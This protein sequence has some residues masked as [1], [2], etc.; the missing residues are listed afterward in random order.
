MYEV[1]EDTFRLI[2]PITLAKGGVGKAREGHK[3]DPETGEEGE[4]EFVPGEEHQPHRII[5]GPASVPVRDMQGEIVEPSGLDLSYFAKHG[6]INYDHLKGPDNIIGQPLRWRVKPEEFYLEALLYR[7]VPK[8]DACWKLFE[9]G[10][11]LAW[12][13]EGKVIERDSAD[14]T[15]IVRAYVINVALTPNPVCQ[16]TYATVAKSLAAADKHDISKTLTTASG[17]PLIPQSIEGGPKQS[18]RK[19]AHEDV[20]YTHLT[21]AANGGCGCLLTSGQ[22]TSFQKG[23]RGALRHFIDCCGA[24]PEDASDLAQRHVTIART[25]G[26]LLTGG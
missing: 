23:Y 25:T 13:V 11:K 1:D 5:C 7:G 17:A 16:E 14:P 2:L 21:K 3:V 26:R 15:H 8:A 20:L 19:R 18:A 10:A 22:E 6:R 12:S 4:A 24:A 9:A